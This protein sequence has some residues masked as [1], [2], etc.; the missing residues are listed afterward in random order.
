MEI[1]VQ[2]SSPNPLLT[3][4]FPGPQFPHMQNDLFKEI[5]FEVD[6]RY[7]FYESAQSILLVG[8]SNTNR[9]PSGR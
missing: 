9:N 4:Y 8:S 2:S 7:G 5:F 6:Y 3:L 1:G